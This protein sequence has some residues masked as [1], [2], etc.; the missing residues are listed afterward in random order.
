M[1][2]R[3]GETNL[4]KV[5]KFSGHLCLMC[6]LLMCLPMRERERVCV[7]VCVLERERERIEKKG[8]VKICCSRMKK[9]IV[10]EFNFL[11]GR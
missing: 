10:K 9:V 11:S 2:A 4:K 6:K 1:G 3:S 5:S 7:C 8:Y